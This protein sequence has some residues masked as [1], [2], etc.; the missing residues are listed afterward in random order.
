MTNAAESLLTDIR[1]LAPDIKSRAAEIETG[2]RV[3]PDLIETLKS[4]GGFR[5]FVPRSHGGLELDF[6]AALEVIEALARTESS[7][8]WNVAISGGTSL[9]ASLLPRDTY[10]LVYQSGPHTIIAGSAQPAGTAEA[11]SG[12][13]RVSG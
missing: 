9:F 10:E 8:G 13:W 5:M 11:T 12:G 4:I 6:P 3:P 7:V 2:R 1:R